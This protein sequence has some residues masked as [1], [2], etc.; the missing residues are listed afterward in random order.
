MLE[1]RKSEDRGHANHG[2]LD[3][4][5][6]FSFA[7]YYDPDHMGFG[8]LRVINDD[9]IVAGAGFGTHGHRDMEI[10]TYVLEGEVAHRDSMGTGSTIRPGDVQRMS[11]GTGVQHSEFNPS[12]ENGTHLLQI[13]IQ[14]A[15]QG[16]PPSYEEKHFDAAEKRGRLRLIA[17]PDAA[18]GSTLIHQDAKVYVGLFDGAE[19]TSLPLAQ[20]RRAYLHVARGEV[21]VNGVSLKA[22]DALKMTDAASVDIA[23]GKAAEVLLFDMV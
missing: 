23:H 12:Q 6:S 20:G 19:R 9:R 21:E 17:S 4:Y 18:D 16:I 8:P 3:S 10:I 14:P 15:V 13:W 2:W 7:D 22:G 5:H 11:A 1:I